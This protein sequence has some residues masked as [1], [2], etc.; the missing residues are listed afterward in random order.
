MINS[1]HQGSAAAVIIITLTVAVI[2]MLGFLFWQSYVNKTNPVVSIASKGGGFEDRQVKTPELNESYTLPDENISFK[3]PDT[4]ELKTLYTSKDTDMGEN[5]VLLISPDNFVLHIGVPSY[6]PSWQFG[7]RPLACPFDDGY[8]G[9][10]GGDDNHP[11]ACP[12][13]KEL[14]SQAHPLL[15]DLSIK[16]FKANWENPDQMP[17][18]INLILVKA[19]CKIPENKHCEKPNANT[20]Y[21]LNVEGA[22]YKNITDEHKSMAGMYSDFEFKKVTEDDFVKSRDVISAIEILKSLNY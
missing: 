14:I 16:V 13:Y 15:K 17:D 22:Y 4:W 9:F 18:K 5:R 21:Y 19:G 10:A 2:G 12:Y 1:R 11:D 8:N 20:G 3:Y 6:G 7:D